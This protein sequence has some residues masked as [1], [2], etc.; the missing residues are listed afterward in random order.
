MPIS[1]LEQQGAPVATRRS[2]RT[3]TRKQR[4]NGFL[5]PALLFIAFMTVYP[6]AYNIWLAVHGT[7][8]GNLLRGS[9]PFVGF[10]NFRT[11]ADD[12]AFRHALLIS[13]VFTAGA[14]FLQ[15]TLGFALALFFSQPFPG[16][17]T[18]RA[19]LLLGWLLPIVVSANVWRWLLDGSYGLFN[20]FLLATGLIDRPAFWLTDQH[21]ALT[22]VILANAWVGVPFNM[23]LLLAGLQGISPSLYEAAMIDGAG[24]WERF[25]F[26]T[27][28]Q[29]RAVALTV[30]LLS[31]VYTFKV[32]DLIFVLT[33]G[34][35]VDATTTLPVYT[36]QLTFTSF[37]FSK[38]AAAATVLLLISLSL[39]GLYV[40]TI[41]REEAS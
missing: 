6:L 12:Q 20:A 7:D 1:S 28:P 16:N 29:V 13:L 19:L 34:G 23:V 35:P 5:L 17:R 8:I 22:A 30:L 39:S 18:L 26:I 33:Q 32:F 14:L 21:A 37:A 41:R 15:F 10:D 9:S 38:G 2:Q 25:R 40:W 24:M 36:Y 27:L 11:L 4:G 3:G 31:F